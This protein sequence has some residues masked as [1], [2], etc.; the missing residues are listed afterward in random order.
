MIEIKYFSSWGL[1]GVDAEYL[2]K[3]VNDEVERLDRLD[4]SRFNEM[5]RKEKELKQ[6]EKNFKESKARLA[7]YR[8]L[9]KAIEKLNDKMKEENKEENKE[10]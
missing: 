9:A 4:K 2:K 3:Y 8:D 1:N 10:G 5:V 6:A 7:M